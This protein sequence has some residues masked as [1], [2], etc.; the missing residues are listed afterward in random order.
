MYVQLLS[1]VVHYTY[2]SKQTQIEWIYVNEQQ[3]TFY[4]KKCKQ[5]IT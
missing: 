3:L 5:K 1:Q 2:K 4:K